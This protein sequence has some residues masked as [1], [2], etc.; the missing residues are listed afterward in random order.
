[1]TLRIS[2]IRCALFGHK[3]VW[4]ARSSA[5]TNPEPIRTE[6]CIRC[7]IR[8][9]SEFEEI[10]KNG[11]IGQFDGFQIYK[12]GEP[13]FSKKRKSEES[14]LINSVPKTLA[15]MHMDIVTRKLKK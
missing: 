10:I 14:S 9:K 15:K 3:F 12:P 11:L 8:E 6:F 2:T 13:L 4:D 7:G 1:M 5:H